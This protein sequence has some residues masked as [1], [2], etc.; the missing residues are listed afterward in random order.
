[1]AAGRRMLHEFCT[2]RLKHFGASRNDPT[3]NA[4][5]GLSPWLHYGEP[6]VR[7]VWECHPLTLT[8]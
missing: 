1:M 4:L 6:R 5:S 7:V 2:E 3:K 8:S